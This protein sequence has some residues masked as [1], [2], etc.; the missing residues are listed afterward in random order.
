MSPKQ[1][2]KTLKLTQADAARLAGVSGSNPSR[3][4]QRWETGSRRPPFQ[5]VAL[6]QK[7]SGGSVCAA[8]WPSSGLVD[9]AKAV[10]A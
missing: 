9:N 4:W 6:V 5:V 3:T 8:S 7:L 2:R 10:A 1:W